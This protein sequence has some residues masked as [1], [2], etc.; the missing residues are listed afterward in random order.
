MMNPTTPTIRRP[1]ECDVITIFT[2]GVECSVLQPSTE[3]SFDGAATLIITGGTPPYTIFWEIGSF[4]PALANIGVGEYRATVV[5]YY[6]DFTANTTCVLT[7]TTETY[8]GVCFVLSGILQNELV[9]ISS[10]SLGLKNGKPYYKLQYG[11]ET[12]G[13]MV[14]IQK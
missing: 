1:N 11:V 9:Y 14:I 7:A 3:R 2:M 13:C 12:Y 6:G 5:D 4:A 10:E 8:S